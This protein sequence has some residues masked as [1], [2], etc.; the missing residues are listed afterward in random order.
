MLRLDH[1][2]PLSVVQERLAEAAENAGHEFWSNDVNLLKK[3]GLVWT[4]V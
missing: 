4:N 2:F 1:Y 3:D